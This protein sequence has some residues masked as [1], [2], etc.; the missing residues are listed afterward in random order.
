LFA[1]L[2]AAFL[3]Q[4][5]QSSGQ[6]SVL[7]NHAKKANREKIRLCGIPH[8]QVPKLEQFVM[9]LEQKHKALMAAS[10]QDKAQIHAYAVLKSVFRSMLTSNGDLFNTV[11]NDVFDTAR[12]AR[13][14]IYDF[15][16][17]LL[18]GHGIAMAQTINVIS[19]ALSGLSK[20]DVVIFYGCDNISSQPVKDYLKH[21]LD[22]LYSRGGRAC[23]IY[24]DVHNYMAD[25]E[26]NG[27]IR[28]DYTV[29]STMAPGD[30]DFYEK[31]FGI[32]LPSG[33]KRLVCETHSS[34]N[35]L[36]RGFDNVVFTPDLYVG[37]EADRRSS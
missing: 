9:N 26:F 30:V 19:Y 6:K 10:V 29:M 24:D 15:S 31:Q 21:E 18:R 33:L 32:D 37:I 28:A 23:F 35:Y 7:Q 16:A 22:F 13:R 2:C 12:D 1:G 27:A 11:T 14:V 17:L 34:H 4:K 5:I 20:D 3:R 25:I 8:K 36:H